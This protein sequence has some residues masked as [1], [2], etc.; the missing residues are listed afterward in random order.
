M[1]DFS[2]YANVAGGGYWWGYSFYT[3]YVV[4]LA[5]KLQSDGDAD[6]FSII[7]FAHDAN[8]NFDIVNNV[9]SADAL[10]ADVQTT[11]AQ[12][13]NFK[14]NTESR[15]GSFLGLYRY[16][17]TQCSTDSKLHWANAKPMF[18]LLAQQGML[19]GSE[20]SL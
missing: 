1:L 4:P 7:F 19:S 18:I 10:G 9:Q 14:T 5:R 8:V 11:F 17:V 13:Q 2:S 20:L 12:L 6:A 16:E 3:G 15:Q